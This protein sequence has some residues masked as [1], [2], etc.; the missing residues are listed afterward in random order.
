VTANIGVTLTINAQGQP[1][2]YSMVIPP[3]SNQFFQGGPVNVDACW[4][5]TVS[6]DVAASDIDGPSCSISWSSTNFTSTV[7]GI[8]NEYNGELCL[9]MG[10]PPTMPAGSIISTTCPV[11]P[12]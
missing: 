9:V 5:N 8:F 4:Q 6:V 2:C 11:C 10:T 3:W 12:Q 7:A 1:S